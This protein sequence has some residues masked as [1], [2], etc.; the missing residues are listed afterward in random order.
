MAFK[1]LA[2]E[3][4]A[5]Q[6]FIELYNKAPFE[7]INGE[8][9]IIMPGVARHVEI[10]R[11]L[12]R[13]L[14]QFVSKHNLGEIYTEAPFVLEY[15]PDWV[16][17][18]RVPDLMFFSRTRFDE[19]KKNMPDWQS[20]PFIIV[21]D[22]AIEIVSPNDTFT[23]INRKVT[24][25]LRDGVRSIWVID[26]QQKNAMIHNQEQTQILQTNDNIIVPDILPEF[27]LLLSGLFAVLD[28]GK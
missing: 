15:K 2:F 19:Y 21:P 26:P 27:E 18:S 24:N 8:R 1:N 4:I 7:I 25:Y 11:A 9:I 10:I 14:D 20:K 28:D 6:E 22:I 17:G 3:G 23:V 5:L 16:R 13:I 12:S